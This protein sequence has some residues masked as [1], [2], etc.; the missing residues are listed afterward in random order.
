[1]KEVDPIKDPGKIKEI[2]NI[3]LK[4]NYRDYFLFVLGIN[5]GFRISDLLSLKVKDV[6][7]VSYIELKEDKTNKNNSRL[8]NQQLKEEIEKYIEGMEDWEYLFQ[9]QKGGAISRVQAY[10]VLKKAAQKVGLEKMGT[11]TLRKTFGYHHYQRNKDISLL[12][13][14]FNHSSPSITKR[15]IGLDQEEQ[16]EAM[17][18]FFL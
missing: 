7:N 12:Q 16:D 6:K 14:M 15:Y 8:I 4:Q 3:L 11:H 17:K 2:K 1:M 10:R 9:S 5:V 13:K 18:D